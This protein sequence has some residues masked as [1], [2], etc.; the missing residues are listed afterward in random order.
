MT[1]VSAEQMLLQVVAEAA[2]QLQPLQSVVVAALA[3]AT[4][5]AGL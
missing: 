5:A 4:A 3:T 2:V 1:A